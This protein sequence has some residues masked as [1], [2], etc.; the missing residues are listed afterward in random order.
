V[1][2]E[3]LKAFPMLEDVL[4]ESWQE[5]MGMGNPYTSTL[6][7]RGYG[8]PHSLASRVIACANRS[9]KGG[10][11]DLLQDISKMVHERLTTMEFVQV[12]RG[13]E[14]SEQRIGQDCV[15]MLHYRLTLEYTLGQ[16]PE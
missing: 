3:F 14:N 16:S 4:M 10:G 9:C 1:A 6:P 2:A 12:C 8:R 11:F 15:N 5:G 13:T 7:T